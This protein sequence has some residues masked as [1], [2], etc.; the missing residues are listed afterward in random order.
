MIV[1]ESLQTFA[2]RAFGDKLVDS[3]ERVMTIVDT[4]RA[5]GLSSERAARIK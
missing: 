1:N 3:V 2:L 5:G 4:A